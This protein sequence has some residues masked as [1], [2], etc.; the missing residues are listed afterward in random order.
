MNTN[1]IWQSRCSLHP[2]PNFPLSMQNIGLVPPTIVYHQLIEHTQG[3]NLT[4][5]HSTLTHATVPPS[6]T[7][8][9]PGGTGSAV[10]ASAVLFT[11]SA[12]LAVAAMV[13][14]VTTVVIVKKKGR[15]A[16]DQDMISSKS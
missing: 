15:W 5:A 16:G 8:M 4:D 11:L 9:V 13:M 6:D 3:R 10:A 14:I 12:L 2:N 7:N 1:D